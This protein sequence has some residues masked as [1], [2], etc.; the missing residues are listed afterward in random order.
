MDI[1][2]RKVTVTGPRGT[3][4]KDFSH[5]QLDLKVMKC[6]TKKH[7]GDMVR[8]QMWNGKYKKACGVSTIRSLIKNMFVGVTQ[9][10][11]QASSHLLTAAKVCFDS[12]LP[13]YF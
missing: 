3:I 8:I 6:T 1:K 13:I 4:K 10:S 11:L 7:K 12:F 9:V 5:L 2:A